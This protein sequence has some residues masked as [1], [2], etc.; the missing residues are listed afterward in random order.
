MGMKLNI[1]YILDIITTIS[2]TEKLGKLKSHYPLKHIYCR[3]MWLVPTCMM[4]ELVQKP[5]IATSYPG[6]LACQ[7]LKNKRE[8]GK[9]TKGRTDKDTSIKYGHVF[10]S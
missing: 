10:L 5:V 6:I 2:F 7:S 8:N 1:I 3:L 4:M 9:R